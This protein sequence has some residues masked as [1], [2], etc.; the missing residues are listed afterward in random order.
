MEDDKLLDVSQDDILVEETPQDSP[1]TFSRNLLSK[2]GI[3]RT[4][5]EAEAITPNNNNNTVNCCGRGSNH[6][7]GVTEQVSKKDQS[8]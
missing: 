1:A 5:P 3:N 6:G 7:V 8:H 4:K 2:L